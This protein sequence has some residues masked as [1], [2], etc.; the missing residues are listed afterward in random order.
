M[1]RRK[2]APA[3]PVTTVEVAIRE[4]TPKLFLVALAVVA[5]EVPAARVTVTEEVSVLRLLMLSVLSGIP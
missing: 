5:L 2:A 4:E 3:I 1:V